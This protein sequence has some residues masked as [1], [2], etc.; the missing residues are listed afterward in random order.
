MIAVDTS[1]L[2][3]ILLDETESARCLAVLDRVDDLC[4]AAP[5][6]TEAMIVAL[7]RSVSSRLDDLFDRLDAEVVP[8]T[9]ARARAAGR[10]Y[11]RYGKSFHAA[12]LNYGDCFSY[13]LAKERDCPLLFVGN[14]FALTDVIPA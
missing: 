5:T 11:D 9:P 4:I 13:A 3:A 14:D 7:R 1:A 2:I 6:V 8:L 10:A 12:S